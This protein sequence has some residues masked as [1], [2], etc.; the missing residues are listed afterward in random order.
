MKE[1]IK[2]EVNWN[3]F[4]EGLFFFVIKLMLLGLGISILIGILAVPLYLFLLA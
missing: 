4:F 1:N 3:D 2:L